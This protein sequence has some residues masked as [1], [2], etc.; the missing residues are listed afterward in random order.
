MMKNVLLIR[1]YAKAFFEYAL[2]NNVIDRC[3]DDLKLV[4]D[5]LK[6]N[7]ELRLILEKSFVSVDYKTDILVKIFKP[8]ILDVS[9]QLLTMMVKKGRS[10][11]IEYV[12][13]EYETLLLDY[14]GISVVTVITALEIDDDTKHRMLRFVEDKV[15]GDIKIE[16]RIDKNIIGGFIVE[17]GDYQ[18]DASVKGVIERLKKNFNKNLF[19]KGY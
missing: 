17:Y 6:E 14:K 13:G 12:F 8:Y 7:D 4:S 5:T 9:M 15:K 11:C 2:E 19:V 1:R 10:S 3:Y 16:S 18:Y